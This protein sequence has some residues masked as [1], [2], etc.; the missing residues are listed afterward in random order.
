MVDETRILSQQEVATLLSAIDGGEVEVTPAPAQ[1]PDETEP[2]VAYDFRRPDRVPIRVLETLEALHEGWLRK[3]GEALSGLFRTR[4]ECRVTEIS[5]L[6]LDDFFRQIPGTPVLSVVPLKSSGGSALMAMDASIAFPFLERLLGSPSSGAAPARIPTPLEWSLLEKAFS[7]TVELLRE[8][9][10]PFGSPDFGAPAHESD[11][12]HLRGFPGHETLISVASE[13]S[14]GDAKGMLSLGLPVAGMAKALE[15]VAAWRGGAT[16]SAQPSAEGALAAAKVQVAAHLPVERMRLKDLEFLVPGGVLLFNLSK[17][18]PI[19]VSI[20]GRPKFMARPGTFKDRRAFKVVSRAEASGASQPRVPVTIRKP[21]EEEGDDTK[22]LV[23]SVEHVLRVPLEPTA[24]VAEA[25][26]SLKE[27]LA[28]RP[29]GIISFGQRYDEPMEMRVAGRAIAK[30]NAV[31]V[32]NR[33]GFQVV[34]VEPLSKT[35]AKLGP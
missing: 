24:V 12:L 4:V 25:T 11:P 15:R 29:G 7:L 19:E 8:A 1:T 35:A 22:A 20:E 31:R 13:L 10:K 9:W 26:M 2:A 18:A 28:V 14:M 23:A 3:V 32:G 5:Q 16:D 34:S 21:E 27:A 17:N 30:G 6:S 33:F